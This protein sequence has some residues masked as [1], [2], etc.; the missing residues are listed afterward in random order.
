MFKTCVTFIIKNQSIYNE[1][2]FFFGITLQS[3]IKRGKHHRG[4]HRKLQKE[5]RKQKLMENWIILTFY[6]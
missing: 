6:C 2:A 1:C 3:A 5:E 4:E